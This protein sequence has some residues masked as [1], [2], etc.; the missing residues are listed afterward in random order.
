MGCGLE[1][2]NGRGS[3][4]V[5][6][7]KSFLALWEQG[8]HWRRRTTGPAG[9]AGQGYGQLSF[10]GEP[11][12]G[13]LGTRKECARILWFLFLCSL[14]FMVPVACGLFPQEW[15]EPIM[16]PLLYRTLDRPA[17]LSRG[18]REGAAG[19]AL[20]QGQVPINLHCGP[21]HLGREQQ[22]PLHGPGEAMGAGSRRARVVLERSCL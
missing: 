22:K 4:F 2:E 9:R 1:W 3:S 7:P 5:P 17:C 18:E 19:A 10:P 11:G 14:I 15:Y 20:V 6:L 8:R 13:G 21:L 16:P 12:G